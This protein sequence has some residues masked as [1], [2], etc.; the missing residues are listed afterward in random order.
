M[1]QPWKG[2]WGCGTRQPPPHLL[3][4]PISCQMHLLSGLLWGLGPRTLFTT[5]CSASLILGTPGSR[6]ESWAL[7]WERP[8]ETPSPALELHPFCQTGWAAQSPQPT[9]P[10]PPDPDRDPGLAPAEGLP[11][12][13]APLLGPAAPTSRAGA[14]PLGRVHAGRAC[15]QS[16]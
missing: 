16:M 2:A 15:K 13:P 4:S 7:G 11:T 10:W 8:W 1:R 12:F 3:P 5:P 6:P 9:V 14:G